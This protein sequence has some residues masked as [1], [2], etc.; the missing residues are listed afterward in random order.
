MAASIHAPSGC[1]RR[2]RMSTVVGNSDAICSART[3][4]SL[5]ANRALH[6][7]SEQGQ[8]RDHAREQRLK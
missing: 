1:E 3:H 7:A 2:R 4:P 5:T 6:D 8:F